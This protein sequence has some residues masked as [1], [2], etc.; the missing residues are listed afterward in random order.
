MLTNNR[1]SILTLLSS[2]SLL[3]VARGPIEVSLERRAE[4]IHA[5]D[6]WHFEPHKLPEHEVL[7]CSLVIFEAL[8]RLEGILDMIPVT[9][10][11][12]ELI[13]LS[14]PC[15][16]PSINHRSGQGSTLQHATCLSSS[17]FIS[18]LRTRP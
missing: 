13:M 14:L 11:A 1:M 6:N 15:L 3:S 18:Q 8:F 4:L 17:K 16:I 10:G 12:H 5:M 9:I 2:S 7:Y